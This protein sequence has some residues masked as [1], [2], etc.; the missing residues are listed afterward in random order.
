MTAFGHISHRALSEQRL[1]TSPIVHYQKTIANFVL[2]IW[3]ES[4]SS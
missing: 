1:V 3:M 4:E 2:N